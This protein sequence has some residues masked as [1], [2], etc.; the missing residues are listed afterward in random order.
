MN[1]IE[2]RRVA[3]YN[4]EFSDGGAHVVEIVGG[5]LTQF[6]AYSVQASLDNKERAMRGIISLRAVLVLAVAAAILGL[7]A[8][9]AP[10]AITFDGFFSW[11]VG[12]DTYDASGSDKLVVAI[13]GENGNPGDLGGNVI[14]ITYNGQTLIKA[15]DVSPSDPATGGHGQ[16]TSDIWYLDNPGNYAGPGTITPTVTSNGNNYVYTAIGLSGTAPGVGATATVSG[17]ASVN[18]TT[19]GFDSIV[20]SLIGMGGQG[21]TASP[22]PGVTA[23]SPAGVITFTGLEAGNNWAGHA[24]ARTDISSPSLQTYSF[25]TTKT[26]V[27]TIAAEFLVPVP[28]LYWDIDGVTPGAG[29]SAPAGVWNATDPNWNAASDGTGSTG[30]WTAGYTARFAA[31]TKATGT[32]TV[33]VDGP[34]GIAGL[35]FEEGTVKLAPAETGGVLRMDANTAVYVA[36]GLSATVETKL[37]EDVAGRQLFATGAGT[38]VLSGANDYTGGTGI[39]AGIVAISGS[40]TLGAGGALTLGGGALNL[41]GTA[42]TV[43]AVSIAAAAAAGDTIGNGSLTGTSYSA[44][45][46]TGRAVISA[47]LLANGAAGLVKSGEGTLVLSGNNTY[48]GKTSINAGILIFGKQ[49]TLNGN[50]DNFTPDNVTAESGAVLGLAVGDSAGLFDSTA[51]DAV[52]DA[53]HLGASTATTGMKPGAQFGLDTTNA[54]DGTF[55]HSSAIGDLTGG[56]LNPVSLAKLGKGT[57]ILGAANT[58]SGATNIAEGTLKLGSAGALPNGN[59]AVNGTLDLNGN[60]ATIKAFN[61]AGTVTNNGG[62]ATLTVG[63]G[64][65]NGTFSGEIKDGVTTA[66]GTVT[67]T[68]WLS[69]DPGNAGNGTFVAG[70]GSVSWN[71]A[72]VLLAGSILRSV[73]YLFR[74]DD[75]PSWS[76]VSDLNFMVGGTA[77]IGADSSATFNYNGG[78]IDQTGVD[79]SGTFTA[80]KNGFPGTLDL[81]TGVG[82]HNFYGDATWSGRFIITYDDATDGRTSLVKVGTGTLELRGI[83]A[84]TGGTTIEAGTL[85]VHA[86]D[87]AYHD[88]LPVPMGDVTIKSGAT[89][90]GNRTNFTGTLTMNGGTWY[91]DNGFNG[92]WTGPVSLGAGT[93][94]TI[95]GLQ[96][97]NGDIS[98]P[99]GLI[100]ESPWWT[101]GELHLNGTNN[102]FEGGVTFRGGSIVTIVNSK[103]LGTGT[104]RTGDSM[105]GVGDRPWR[106]NG[107]TL[108]VG[109]DMSL[110]NP[111]DLSSGGNLTVIGSNAVLSGPISGDGTLTKDGVNTLTLTSA[112]THTGKTSVTNGTLVIG[113]ALALQNSVLNNQATISF[114]TLDSVV[115]GGLE[116]SVDLPASSLTALT[117]GNNNPTDAVY[118]GNINDGAGGLT[119]TKVGANTQTL[120]G[121]INNYTGDTIV[122]G[123][124]LNLTVNLVDGDLEDASTVK[125]F[126]D[127]HMGLIFDGTDTISA[128]WLGGNPMPGG[129][130]YGNSN[131]PDYFEGDGMLYVPITEL[132]GDINGDMV[133]DAAD[134]IALKQNMGMTGAQWTDGDFSRN[135]TVDWDDLQLMMANFGATINTP[136]ATTPEPATL[137]VMMAAGLPALLKRRRR[138]RS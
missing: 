49:T 115:L 20:I 8:G 41:G 82:F 85:Y 59:V 14:G 23:T 24:V 22:L 89:L 123:G 137:F 61:G 102:T 30:A 135:G 109:A 40:G 126:T 78:D 15:V 39:V 60:S 95:Q 97:I 106:I 80:G 33:F 77:I 32:Y 68:Y 81:N 134:F 129:V 124:T 103:G 13:T 21:N 105:Y 56:D 113:N 72:G 28:T 133:V 132:L 27:V 10:A 136:S 125:V 35:T 1:V 5:N 75:N 18:L 92:S 4:W 130:S 64:D 107:G 34:Q 3:G 79:V 52:L 101:P 2:N 46:S 112:N 94:S 118:S 9:T 63:D 76:W 43:G 38:L 73:D 131:Y 19:T 74:I 121:L 65:S 88:G 55:T 117:L 17:A 7:A 47:A 90:L 114:G 50:I 31:G 44:S 122:E 69:P 45:N 87:Y 54:T 96:S 98:G 11:D 100:V 12:P 116:G 16:T 99:G 83:I 138:V 93:T 25:N 67:A 42:Q 70:G 128:L 36:P 48:T 53:D 29:G 57:L 108:N 62:A 104:L 37:T 26:D 110:A 71:D 51:I 86:A 6:R 120:S 66:I 91:D 58:Y 111:I 127:A 84:Y 119:L